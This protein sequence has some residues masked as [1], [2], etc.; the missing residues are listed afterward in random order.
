MNKALLQQLDSI[1][2]ENTIGE[3][4]VAHNQFYWSLLQLVNRRMKLPVL[5][6][7]NTGMQITLSQFPA[8]TQKFPNMMVEVAFFQQC[9]LERLGLQVPPDFYKRYPQ[10]LA[11]LYLLNSSACEI[12]RKDGQYSLRTSSLNV[13]KSY[14][15]ELIENYSE[16]RHNTY[17][18]VDSRPDVERGVLRCLEIRPTNTHRYRLFCLQTPVKPTILIPRFLLVEHIKKILRIL[19]RNE[20]TMR[21]KESNGAIATFNVSLQKEW[22]RRYGTDAEAIQTR[23][24]NANGIELTLAV[25]P[26]GAREAQI[27]TISTLGICSIVKA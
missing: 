11:A 15:K 16:K 4:H 17:L 9:L 5:G 26:V 3:D 22:L 25:V 12:A 13:V 23:C 20:V 10:E 27:K 14:P 19:S 24:L 21:Y 1:Y 18:D 8:A 6:E 2:C 7:A